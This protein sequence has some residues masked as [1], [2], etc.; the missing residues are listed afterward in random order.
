ML[1]YACNICTVG[2]DGHHVMRGNTEENFNSYLDIITFTD[3]CTREGC[4]K[5][6]IIE[7]IAPLFNCLGYS[8]SKTGVGGIAVGFTV[9]NETVKKYE[10]ITGKK[11]SYGIFAVAQSKL[12]DSSIFDGNGNA[13]DG[14]ITANLTSYAFAT[15]E[16]KVTG[17]TDAQKSMALAMGAYVKVT[18]GEAIEYS[19]L[20]S[21]T[22]NANEKY[23][24]VSYNDIVG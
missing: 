13:I 17:F 19:Y 18:D 10:D 15:F 11:L 2:F 16:V 5:K 20:Q 7:T 9:N 14:A 24:F 1:I 21:E 22:P 6:V 3:S 12:G 23:C 4:G 8:A